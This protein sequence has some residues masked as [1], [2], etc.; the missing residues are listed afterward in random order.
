M[1]HSTEVMSF[2]AL[3]VTTAMGPQALAQT[4]PPPPATQAPKQQN[5]HSRAKGAAAGA[6]IGAATGNAARGAAVGAV[7]GG[8]QQRQ[9]RRQQRRSGR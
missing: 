1:K 3:F 5:D 7:V 6:A 2:V 9:E 8:T 4:Q